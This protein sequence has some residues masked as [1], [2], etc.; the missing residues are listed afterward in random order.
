VP[1]IAEIYADG[2]K[3]TLRDYFAAWLPSRVITL[4]DVGVL[5]GNFFTPI[6]NLKDSK[7]NIPFQERKDSDLAPIDMQSES[8]VTTTF[9]GVGDIS[10]ALPNVPQGEAG[11]KI[12]F[13]HTGAFVLQATETYEPYIEDILQLQEHVIDAFGDGRWQLDWAVVTRVVVAPSATILVSRSSESKIEFSAKGD[14]SAGS[15]NLGDAKVKLGMR[16]Q[17]GNIFKMAGVVNATPLFQLAKIKVPWLRLPHI[18]GPAKSRAAH[19]ET[20]STVAPSALIT[21]QRV[22][23]EPSIA[24]LMH[25]ELVEPPGSQ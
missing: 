4:G 7:I 20:R 24:R 19:M 12:E 8:G 25:L 16:S 17:S 10:T 23:E 11:V 14:V 5:D 22:R 13:G 3:S 9:K 18:L 2:V 21:P 1:S 6:T 15:F